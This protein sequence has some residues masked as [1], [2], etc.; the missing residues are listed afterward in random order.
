MPNSICGSI[1]SSR[2]GLLAF[3][4][5]LVTLLTMI[6]F[7]VALL[8]TISAKNMDQYAA[9][10]EDEEEDEDMDPEIAVT[11]RAMAFAALWTA[12]LACLMSIFGT[13]ILGFQSPTG[14]Y[15]TC[16][17]GNVHRITPLGLGS[18]IG[19]LLMFAN[20]TLVCSV[21]FGEF[22]IQDYAME[23]DRN[24]GEDGEKN[25]VDYAQQ[26]AVERSS[27]AFSIMCMF[28]TVLYAGFAAT[29]YAFSRSVLEENLE[30]DEDAYRLQQ[31]QQQ[32]YHGGGYITDNRFDVHPSSKLG[33]AKPGF[34]GAQGSGDSG[35]A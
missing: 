29:V 32:P 33:F 28:L 8:F 1:V 10:E 20:L 15:Y 30:D 16:C 14:Q 18:F 35:L 3:T 2:R 13:V 34:M 6:A 5:S 26:R 12:V 25:A 21:L 27:M 17:A 24:D 31:Q 19:A 11:S 4:W 23:E 9:Q 22:E 7:I